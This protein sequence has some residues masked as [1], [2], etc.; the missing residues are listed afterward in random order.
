MRFMFAGVAL[1]AVLPLSGCGQPVADN[2]IDVATVLN[3]VKKELNTYALA[4]EKYPDT[5]PAC[6]TGLPTRLGLRVD[7]VTVTLKVVGITT[8]TGNAKFGVIPLG[9][10]TGTLSA[11]AEQARTQTQ[12]LTMEFDTVKSV[13]PRELPAVTGS[14]G[15][16]DKIPDMGL[17]NALI[18]VRQGLLDTDHTAK[19][20]LKL[21]QNKTKLS[22]LMGVKTTAGGSAGLTVPVLLIPL[23]IGTGFS[24]SRED[25]QTVEVI[26]NANEGAYLLFK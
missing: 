10:A 17:Y 14:N 5:F 13:A 7:H 15:R 6:D 12:S 21:T 2:V 8:A 25:T 16:P 26:L 1:L 24:A 11:S 9:M 20:C 23:T 19:P 18:D 3:Q 22:I 4:N